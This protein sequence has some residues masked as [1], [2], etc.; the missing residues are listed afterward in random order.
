[1]T[2]AD[3]AGIAATVVI[4]ADVAEHNVASRPSA[5]PFGEAEGRRRTDGDFSHA[6]K[7]Q[8]HTARR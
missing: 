5:S 2:A 8:G 4:A 1:M 6:R 7:T 3:A